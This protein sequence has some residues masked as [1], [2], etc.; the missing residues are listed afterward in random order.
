LL[1]V[2]SILLFGVVMS[3]VANADNYKQ[4]YNNLTSETDSLRK[5]ADSLARQINEKQNASRNLE[6]KLNNEIN[7]L[8]TQLAKLQDDLSNAE[9]EKAALLQKVNSWTGVVENFTKTNQ[10][11]A[12]MLDEKLKQL[13]DT[14]AEL[15]R[16]RKQLKETTAALV[17]KMAIIDT[18]D[19]ETRQLREE[20]AELQARLDEMLRP[21]G[22]VAAPPTPVTA[23]PQV[24]RPVQRLT[25][26]IGLAGRVKAVDLKNSM[27]SITLGSADGVKVGMKFHVTRG[28]LFLC[29]ILIIAVDTEEAVGVLD[30]V[31]QNPRVGD[32]VSTNL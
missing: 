19:A 20:K 23:G 11:Q 3:Y 8:K 25:K 9:R 30:L 26:E 22:R 17:E 14:Q 6:N 12:Q 15:I 16:E 21:V 13:K 1:A 2:S 10:Q 27:A 4:K 5:K 7:N 24:A 31:Q 32:A 28:E 18:L 29:D